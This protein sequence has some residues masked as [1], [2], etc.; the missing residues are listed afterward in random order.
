MPVPE[1][2]P[3]TIAPKTGPR[4][5]VTCFRCSLGLGGG[6]RGG[7]GAG[8]AQVCDGEVGEAANKIVDEQQPPEST[9]SSSRGGRPPFRDK[10]LPLG[11]VGALR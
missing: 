2:C 9:V 4:V 1:Q 6:G 10:A 7:E 3:R 5:G 11:S 8:E